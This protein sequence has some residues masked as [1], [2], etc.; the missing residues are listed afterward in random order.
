VLNSGVHATLA[1]TVVGLCVPLKSPPGASSG[2]ERSLAKRCI[3]VLH[4]WVAF[5]IMPVFAFANAGV[6]LAGL[7]GEMIV[8]PVTLGVALGLFLGK[9]IGVMTAIVLSRLS[10]ICRLPEGAGWAETYGVA[11]LTG[12]GFTMSLFI[13]GLA[14]RNHDYIVEMRLGVIGG[15]ILSAVSGLLVL[16]IATRRRMAGSAAQ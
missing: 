4:P 1:G 10:G 7:S 13:G 6:S 11:V 9:Q 15:S 8:A 16:A 14:F 5:G 2:E 3:H 12:I